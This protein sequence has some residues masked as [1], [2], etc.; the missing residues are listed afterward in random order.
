MEDAMKLNLRLILQAILFLIILTGTTYG[1]STALLSDSSVHQ[2]VLDN[3]MKYYIQPNGHPKDEVELRLIVHVGSLAEKDDEQ[4]FAHF[5]EHMCFNGTRHYPGNEIIDYLESEGLRFG[6]QFNA[7]TS[8]EE[9]VYM[10]T[11]PTEKKELLG[12]GFQILTDWAGHVSF[13]EEEIEKERGVIIQEWRTG[14]GAGERLRRQYYPV[15]FGDARHTHRMPIGKKPI[16]ESFSPQSLRNFYDKWYRPELMSAV[17]VG[18][19]SVQEAEKYIKKYFGSLPA[20]EKD[21]APRQYPV[22]DKSEVQAK[23]CIDEEATKEMIRMYFLDDKWNMKEQED[24][25]QKLKSELIEMIINDRF[26]KIAK[27][28]DSPYLYAHS[29][30]GRLVNTKDAFTYTA[31]TRSDQLMQGYRRLVKENRRLMLHGFNQA[32]LKKQKEILKKN[33]KN[34]VLKGNKIASDQLADGLQAHLL[35]DKAVVSTQKRYALAQRYLPDIEL[36]DLNNEFR[37]W[38][39]AHPVIIASS[40]NTDLSAKLDGEQLKQIYKKELKNTPAPY[41]SDVVTKTLT[42]DNIQKGKIV[43]EKKASQ[44]GITRWTLSNGAEVILKPTDFS[45]NEVL[46]TGVSKGGQSLYDNEDFF[47]ARFSTKL[48]FMSG[49]KDLTYG[50]VKDVLAAKTVRLSPWI[51]RH[52]EGTRGSSSKADVETL[53][54]LNHL[55]FTQPRFDSSA[56]EGYLSRYKTQITSFRNSPDFGFTDTIT[57]VL[58]GNSP[59]FF[60]LPDPKRIDHELDYERAES[61]YKERF[62]DAGD[63]SFIFVGNIDEDR[64]KPLVEKYI[65][66]L[67]DRGNKDDVPAK[68]YF[69][70]EGKKD[71]EVY[72]GQAEKSMVNITYAG[73]YDSAPTD[74]QALTVLTEILKVKLRNTLREEKSGVYGINVGSNIYDYPSDAFKLDVSFECAPSMV[75]ELIAAVEKEIHKQQAEGPEK[76]SMSKAKMVLRKEFE[77]Q[78]KDNRFWQKQIREAILTDGKASHVLQDYMKEIQGVT[79]NDVQRV[80]KTYLTK[81]S[82]MKAILF[83]EER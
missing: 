59:R 19:I 35:K 11:L 22:K 14:Q 12:N 72:A 60:F 38:T 54:K 52:A 63:F 65:A 66:S 8:F 24:F 33:Y 20:D 79:E 37:E 15:I 53:L 50:E 80:A 82:K 61:I 18:D 31:V 30:K 62:A 5:V 29:F 39:K 23:V 51:A 58:H 6:R 75:D 47:S 21:L 83:P 34:E 57:Q 4:G 28:S 69:N 81:N 10:L 48:A 68:P 7:Y 46:F 2:G 74:E 25:K 56:I 71:V 32:E 3:G 36:E 67:P 45:N 1:Q 43:R 70:F 42:P 26:R 16:L 76:S 9:T 49:V 44:S 77:R 27:S 17:V 13:E 64:L 78:S 55:Y 40:P 73:N 41:K